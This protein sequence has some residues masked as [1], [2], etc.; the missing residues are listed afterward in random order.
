MAGKNKNNIGL[1]IFRVAVSLMLMV[2]GVQKL[3]VLLS[4]DLKFSDPIGLGPTTTLILVLIAEIICPVMIIVGYKTRLA[5]IP[6]IILMLVAAFIVKAGT[7]FEARELALL[8]LVSFVVMGLLG[9]GR[10]SVDRN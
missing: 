8:Y 5:V 1:F 9:P 6:P 7:A 3:D 4:S 2:H 10:L